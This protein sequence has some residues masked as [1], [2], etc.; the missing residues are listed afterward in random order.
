MVLRP[1]L[2]DQLRDGGGS[3]GG[4]GIGGRVHGRAMLSPAMTGQGRRQ[5]RPAAAHSAN[6][7]RA[8][9]AGSGTVDDEEPGP[10]GM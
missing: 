4:H 8:S 1:G 10:D 6:P 7:A 5:R 2:V 3:P 9:D